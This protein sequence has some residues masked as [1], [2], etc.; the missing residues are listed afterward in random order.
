M[1]LHEL[2]KAVLI[3]VIV[4]A[5]IQTIYVLLTTKRLKK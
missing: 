4:S 3:F 5:T 2:T 1:D